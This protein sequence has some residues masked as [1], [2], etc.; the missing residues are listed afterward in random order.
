MISLVPLLMIAGY[1]YLI[2]R[3][4]LSSTARRRDAENIKRAAR[5]KE[6]DEQAGNGAAAAM[7]SAAHY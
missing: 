5:K 7:S 2:Y 1:G 3:W 4:T 6:R